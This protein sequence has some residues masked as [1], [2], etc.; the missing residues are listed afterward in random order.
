M[1]VPV[2]ESILA[3]DG[4]QLVILLVGGTK[5]RQSANIAGAKAN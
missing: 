4:N 2:I 1:S 5:K 3:K